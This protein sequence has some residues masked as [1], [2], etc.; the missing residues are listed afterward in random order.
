MFN[1]RQLY[2][3]LL[4][5]FQKLLPNDFTSLLRACC[6]ISFRYNVIGNLVTNEQERVY[7]RVAT[8]LSS[9]EIKGI[10]E[11]L[12]SLK[13]IYVADDKFRN[14]F[15]DKVLRTTQARN[16]RIVRY[17]LFAVERHTSGKEYDFESDLYNIEHIMPES[18][19]GVWD[20]IHDRDHEQF[21]FRLG[22]MTIL[23]KSMNRNLGN[24]DF[25]TKRGVFSE[26]EFMITQRIAEEN[27]D[28]GPARIASHQK[29]L[30]RQATAIW[31]IPR[32]SN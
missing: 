2:P 23:K 27:N 31:R 11:V 4:A 32:L 13:S 21:L 9:E 16:K 7:N 20:H 5:G 15:A 28:W 24:A 1:V 8:Q 3:L 29:W 6:V 22:N 19:D 26:S 10:N 17:I 30:T 25:E 14:D 18:I 12:N